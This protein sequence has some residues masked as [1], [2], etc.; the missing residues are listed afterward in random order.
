M[1]KRAGNGKAPDD[2]EEMF[3]AINTPRAPD[4]AAADGVGRA[5]LLAAL[6]DGS[7]FAPGADNLARIAGGVAAGAFDGD[8]VTGEQRRRI[9]DHLGGVLKAGGPD[10][11]GPALAALGAIL[12][13]PGLNVTPGAAAAAA[14]APLVTVDNGD[15]PGADPPPP[16]GRTKRGRF[17]AGNHCA[18]GN[19]NHRRAAMLRAA[20]GEGVGADEMKALGKKL[21]DQALS[22]DTV[23]ARLLLE[24]VVGKPR[25]AP[26]P[27]SLDALEWKVLTSGPTLAALWH[28]AHEVADPAFAC[29]VWKKL[30]A[31]SADAAA[32]QLVDAVQREP[33]RFARD[34]AAERKAKVGR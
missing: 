24:Y 11:K 10:E 9:L 26:D 5:E 23:A 30:S 28:A 25:L 29:A 21:Y 6:A 16:G 2:V 1:K 18:R 33:G 20:L 15:A 7:L 31:A 13:R 27:D 8:A 22:G 34:L 32:D 12:Q 4:P 3:R 14:P 17:A 19:P